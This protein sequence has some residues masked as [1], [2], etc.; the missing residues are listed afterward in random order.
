MRAV[1]LPV[2]IEYSYHARSCYLQQYAVAHRTWI[3]INGAKVHAHDTPRMTD[4]FKG[5][6]AVV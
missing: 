4:S 5:Y 2:P 1:L 6:K 3:S